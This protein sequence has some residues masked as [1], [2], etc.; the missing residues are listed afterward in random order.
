M[1]W[2]GAGNGT[3]VHSRTGLGRMG[4]TLV[5]EFSI[6]LVGVGWEWGSGRIGKVRVWW[7][8]AYV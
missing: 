8:R 4:Y 7:G 3:A 6:C 2:D 5:R 1:G